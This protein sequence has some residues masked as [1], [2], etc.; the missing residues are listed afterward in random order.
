MHGQLFKGIHVAKLKAL[1]MLANDPQKINNPIKIF[2]I[3]PN[4]IYIIF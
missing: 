2:L 3:H 4:I 1:A